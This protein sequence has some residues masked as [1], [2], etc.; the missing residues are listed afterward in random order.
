[1]SIPGFKGEASM[2]RSA[3]KYQLVWAAGETLGSGIYSGQIIPS[4]PVGGDTGICAPFCEICES[5]IASRTGCSQS[6]TAKNCNEY[7]RSCTGC[8]NACQGGQFCAG[9]C[10]DTRKDANNCG[11]CGNKCSPG[12]T[13]QNGTCGCPPGEVICNGGC[14]DTSS[15]PF[16]C[17]ACGNACGAGQ[18]CQN[19]TCVQANCRVF[20]STWVSC[21]QTCGAWP[22]GLGNYQC[23]LDCLGPD[24]DCLTATCS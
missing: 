6:C 22:P 4:L 14:T 1:M 17:G 15:N 5:D 19:G 2:Y 16:N 13:C 24:I 8:S 12:V 23:W 3:I 7:T 21:N 18:I 10:T 20:C 9:V 11:G